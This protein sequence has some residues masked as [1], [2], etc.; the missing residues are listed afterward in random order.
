[1]APRI[2]RGPMRE[3]APPATLPT[4]RL[5]AFHYMVLMMSSVP[6]QFCLTSCPPCP[7]PTLPACLTLFNLPIP[8]A[9][10]TIFN[11]PLPP[12]HL[13]SCLPYLPLSSFLPSLPPAS[14]Y[15]LASTHLTSCPPD[16]LPTLPPAHLTSCP[17]YL[18]PTLRVPPAHLTSYLLYLTY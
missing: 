11:L 4:L 3:Y 8:P 2:Q 10:H 1:M 17:P 13:I 12:P 14:P 5:K 6:L 18:L 9:C 15:L 7:L 16:L